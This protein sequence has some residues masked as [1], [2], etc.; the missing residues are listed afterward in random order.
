MSNLWKSVCAA[1]RHT[2]MM[3]GPSG[4]ERWG[5]FLNFPWTPLRPC[6]PGLTTRPRGRCV[7]RSHAKIDPM[8]YLRPKLEQLVH[9]LWLPVWGVGGQVDPKWWEP[10][11]GTPV[12]ARSKGRMPEERGAV[13]GPDGEPEQRGC[14]QTVCCLWGCFYLLPGALWPQRVS[15]PSYLVQENTCWFVTL[16]ST[17]SSTMYEQ[18]RKWR[19]R[20]H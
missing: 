15:T 13:W 4:A 16:T 9:W 19:M 7:S 14:S 12:G 20:T 17:S 11:E 10:A 6:S 1:L 2:V 8:Y 3:G 5:A 18:H